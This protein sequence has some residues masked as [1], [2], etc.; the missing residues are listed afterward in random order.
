[1][2]NF[3]LKYVFLPL[4]A[5]LLI[6][7]CNEDKIK[8]NTI[9]ISAIMDSIQ[10]ST[11]TASATVNPTG[12]ENVCDGK[13]FTGSPLTVSGD[14]TGNTTWSNA[15][16]LSG[17][18]TVKNN[19]TLTIQ[20]GTVVFGETGSSLF[21]T[22]GSKIEAVGTAL[23]PIC[24]TSAKNVGFRAPGDWGGLVI[25]GNARG[26]RSSTT[27]GIIPLPYGSGTNDSESSGTL[28]YVIVEFAGNEVSPGDEL[29]GVSSYTIGSGTSFDFVQ[30][31]RGL[32]DGFE[33]WGGA[34]VGKHLLVTGGM[35]DD[36][37]FDEGFRGT[38]Q[39]LIGVKYP[40]SCGGT[41]S[42]DPHG[43]EMDGMHS[44]VS[45]CTT[46]PGCSNPSVSNYVL[47]G[48]QV[49]GSRA[50]RH[51]EGMQG[52][53]S[54]GLS[55]NFVTGITCENSGNGGTTGSVF[56]KILSDKALTNGASCTGT[57]TNSITK[58]PITS[59]GAIDSTNC[60]N[61]TSKPDFNII[62]EYSSGAAG[63][64]DSSNPN[65]WA[66]WTVYRSK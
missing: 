53:F 13:T 9:A 65:W 46:G 41:P 54:E 34:P 21:I 19:S 61:G 24:F 42:S 26:T 31:H 37:D 17:T 7:N 27:E 50:Q 10:A 14:I 36:F 25:I 56:N 52:T 63:P 51:R 29:N 22:Q 33:F 12:G 38:L 28:K 47:I 32:D 5:I 16:K 48:Q 15:I 20:P 35:D 8:T 62:S 2:V 39:Y 59:L 44:G 43:M 6:V 11:T 1:M 40:V 58:L 66:D 64:V 57:V 4:S 60:G 30:V 55:Y 3:K 49:A 18:V 45:N 23:L